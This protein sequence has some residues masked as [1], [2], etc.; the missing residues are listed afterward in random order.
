MPG[1]FAVLDEAERAIFVIPRVRL[2]EFSRC[3]PGLREADEG[4]PRNTKG[5]G[6]VARG[7]PEAS[8]VLW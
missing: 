3:L 5:R 4:V 8:G 2:V 1:D 6:W 7:V